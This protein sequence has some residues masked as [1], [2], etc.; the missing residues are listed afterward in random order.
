[1]YPFAMVQLPAERSGS[2]PRSK[3]L[4]MMMD[5]GLPRGHLRDLLGLLAPYVDYAKFVVGT[6]R[7]HPVDYLLEKLEIY[8]EFDV[9]PII[10]G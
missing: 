9:H 4:T 7:L 2:N 5:F 6:A 8:L 10:G 1:M 3:G